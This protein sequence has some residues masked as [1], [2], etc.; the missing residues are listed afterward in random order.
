MTAGKTHHPIGPGITTTVDSRTRNG[1][2][3]AN[4]GRDRWRASKLPPAGLEPATVGLKSLRS[5]RWLSLGVAGRALSRRS[6]AG[7]RWGSPAVARFH[8]FFYGLESSPDQVA[9]ATRRATATQRAARSTA[10][11]ATDAAMSSGSYSA[12]V[13]RDSRRRSPTSTSAPSLLPTPTPRDPAEPETSAPRSH[14]K[15]APRSEGSAPPSSPPAQRAPARRTRDHRRNRTDEI[16]GSWLAPNTRHKRSTC[17]IV[18]RYTPIRT[19]TEAT[20]T[21][22]YENST[23]LAI[24]CSVW[25]DATHARPPSGR[26]SPGVGAHSTTVE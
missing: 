26:T 9:R 11:V 6:V 15:V 8:G 7:C 19:C 24:G 23:P 25:C 16:H 5:C 20:H 1:G 14:R 10:L 2:S 4:H 3:D 18:E 13:V 22:E 21:I 17:L 12:L